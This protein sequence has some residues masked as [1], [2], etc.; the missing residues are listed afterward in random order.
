MRYIGIEAYKCDTLLQTIDIIIVDSGR[1]QV[2][3]CFIDDQRR[4]LA[5]KTWL[6][7]VFVHALSSLLW[8]VVGWTEKGV[9]CFKIALYAMCCVN[10]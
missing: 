8:S 10:I 6:Q 2:D 3:H 9:L 4:S 5:S 7:F 1:S